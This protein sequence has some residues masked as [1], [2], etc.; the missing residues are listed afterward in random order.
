VS[1]ECEDFLIKMFLQDIK[2]PN[3][4]KISEEVVRSAL[5]D[6]GLGLARC[7][8]ELQEGILHKFIDFHDCRLV[9]ATITVVGC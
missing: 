7:G 5:T 9:S 1:S 3:L 8:V 2:G 6:V 4:M